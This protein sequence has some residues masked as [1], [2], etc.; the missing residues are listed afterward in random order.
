MSPVLESPVLEADMYPH[1]M[2]M[3]VASAPY[4]SLLSLR[5]ASRFFRDQ[6]DLALA[7]HVSIEVTD[8]RFRDGKSYHGFTPVAVSG[9]YGRL[10]LFSKWQKLYD[11]YLRVGHDE[12]DD[13]EKGILNRRQRAAAALSQTRIFDIIGPVDPDRLQEVSAEFSS[14]HLRTL[15]FRNR[16]GH[17]VA[18]TTGIVW[19]NINPDLQ[20]IVF[21]LLNPTSRHT[22]IDAFIGF[23][24]PVTKRL[25]VNVDYHP[26]NPYLPLGVIEAPS[27]LPFELEEIVYIFHSRPGTNVKLAY[28]QRASGQRRHPLGVLDQVSA[29]VGPYLNKVKCTFVGVT[30]MPPEVF[31]IDVPGEG[32]SAGDG[33]SGYTPEMIKDFIIQHMEG[34]LRE[35]LDRFGPQ[36]DW[37]DEAIQKAM[38]AIQFLTLDQ[39]RDSVG[40]EFSL[41]T[42]E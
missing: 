24:P 40:E 18:D 28:R 27:P 6:C 31:G 30:D 41:E 15:R 13:W 34:H 32:F 7:R 38:R 11:A 33:N 20:V 26:L 29:E 37:T 35:H 12:P 2:D 16:S 3:I 39:F 14:K 22:D 1:L 25:V 21:T 10:P 36:A 23:I 42:E 4:A 8:P 17:G 19:S 9:R 5:A